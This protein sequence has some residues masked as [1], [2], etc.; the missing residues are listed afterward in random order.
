MQGYSATPPATELCQSLLL[1][2][3]SFSWSHG[4]AYTKDITPLLL[5][6]SVESFLSSFHIDHMIGHIRTQHVEKYGVDYSNRHIFATADHINAIIEFYGPAHKKKGGYLWR[7]L[8]TIENKIVTG[9]V[10][11]FG[12]IMHLPLHWVS[13]VID[14]QHMKILFG[15][16]L[17]HQIPKSNY[18]ACKQWTSHLIK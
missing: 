13:I 8:M 16:S 12:G 6:S 17:G 3:S 5:D 11:S 18:Q 14:F 9:E 2:L 10:D 1:G 7:A 15:D 4:A